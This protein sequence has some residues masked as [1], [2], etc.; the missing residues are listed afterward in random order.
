M[1]QA[2]PAAIG[3]GSSAI[4]GASGKKGAKKQNQLAQQQLKQIQPL[5]DAIIQ[6][7]Q[8]TQ[9]AGQNQF[10][11]GQPI[12]TEGATGLR[13]STLDLSNFYRPL[14]S[15]DANAINSFLAPERRAI[16]QGYQS[17]RD[18]IARFAPRGGGKVASLVRA[19][20]DRQGKLSDLNFG[21]R[22]AGAEG[23]SQ[24]ANQFGQLSGLGLQGTGQGLGALGNASSGAGSIFGQL[25]N[26]QNNA[27]SQQ[28][29]G[30]M[31]TLDLGKQL[32]GF[33]TDLFKGGGKKQAASLPSATLF[34]TP[35]FNPNAS[36]QP[37]LPDFN[38]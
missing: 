35:G 31:N 34:K 17:T 28:R 12:Y 30:G 16:N 14:A 6:S 36:S 7:T 25:Q 3:L 38:F 37:F 20:V 1:P 19:D 29:L 22:R 24:V 2:I 10:D 18:Q 33:L 9:A 4:G 15:G 13:R 5:I 26:S 8:Q 11:T 23:L 27:L 21:A 32:G